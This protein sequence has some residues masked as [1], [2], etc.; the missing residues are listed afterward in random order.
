MIFEIDIELI[1][2]DNFSI[3]INDIESS[4]WLNKVQHYLKLTNETKSHWKLQLYNY[5]SDG[6]I[7]L[8]QNKQLKP[9]TIVNF[10][11]DLYNQHNDPIIF[12]NEKYY[13]KFTHKKT[14]S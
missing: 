9:L 11:Q 4:N 7:I 3:E 8:I 1:N 2:D 12:E 6:S 5:N 14:F 10:I 13:I